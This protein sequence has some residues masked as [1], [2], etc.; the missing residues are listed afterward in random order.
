MRPVCMYFSK[1]E[2][3]DDDLVPMCTHL[4]TCRG[5]VPA[6]FPSILISKKT[7]LVILGPFLVSSAHEAGIV[8]RAVRMIATRM[9]LRFI[10]ILG[11]SV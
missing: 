4:N 2:S 5:H 10:I 11:I 3:D 7:L 6:S 9:L 8:K 1:Y